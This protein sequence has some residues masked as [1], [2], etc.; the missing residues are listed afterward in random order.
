MITENEFIDYMDR[1]NHNYLSYVLDVSKWNNACST[2]MFRDIQMEHRNMGSY[3]ENP[4]RLFNFR[5]IDVGRNV[6]HA[7]IIPDKA[8]DHK[9]FIFHQDTENETM[10][11]EKVRCFLNGGMPLEEALTLTRDFIRL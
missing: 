8:G 3:R 11:E 7:Y 4:N 9:V 2:F 5:G 10:V 1:E 6:Y